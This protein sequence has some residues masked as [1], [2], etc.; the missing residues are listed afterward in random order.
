MERRYPL[1]HSSSESGQQ[2]RAESVSTSHSHSNSD[3]NSNNS[4][5]N[6]ND[7][8]INSNSNSNDKQQ[9]S[10]G[11]IS[12]NINY[13][14]SDD[15]QSS[16][17]N[18][19][20]D[21]I[22]EVLQTLFKTVNH[23]QDAFS[24]IVDFVL[25]KSESGGKFSL[26][27]VYTINNIWCIMAK[28]FQVENISFPQSVSVSSLDVESRKSTPNPDLVFSDDGTVNEEKVAPNISNNHNINSDRNSF[29]SF[30]HDN[31]NSNDNKQW[32]RDRREQEKIDRW[33]KCFQRGEL[34][35]HMKEELR[36]LFLATTRE[37]AQSVFEVE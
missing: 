11:P 37:I 18:D 28:A 8:Y 31:S 2:T 24:S 34:P 33:S 9:Y 32:P 10:R 13:I 6:S 29:S 15:D 27:Q 20:G 23:N 30:S 1:I 22:G 16:M 35:F 14:Q 21:K 36:L 5:S 12:S 25:K 4:S 3:S 26:Y 7:R 17:Y 19:G